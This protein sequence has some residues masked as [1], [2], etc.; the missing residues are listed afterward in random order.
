LWERHAGPIGLDSGALASKFRFTPGQIR[1]A[2][3][4]AVRQPAAEHAT[5]ADVYRAC[6]RRSVSKL[7]ALG[8]KATPVFQLCDIVLPPDALQQLREICWHA[9]HRE[10]VFGAW[11]FAGKM[12]LGRGLNALLIGAPGTGKTM[13]AEIIAAEIGLDLY[14]LDL[15][16][17]VSKYIGE[18]EK[19]LGQVFQEAARANAVLLF[20][21]AD[22]I[23]GKR[24]E[25]RDAHDRYANIEINYLLQKMEEFDGIVVLASNFHRNIDEAFRRRMRFVVEFPF[26]DEEARRRIWTKVFPQ[27]APLAAEV[28]FGFLAARFKMAGGNIRNVALAAAFLAAAH[29]TAIGMEE[30]V[31]AVRREFQKMGRV[32]VKSDFEQYV[33]LFEPEP[34]REEVTA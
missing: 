34:A 31:R 19:N 3:R 4:E 1:E 13:A 7:A 29:G 8:H 23:F 22:A 15:S 28:D 26:P 18:T 6:R 17:L 12:S 21:E 27:G 25:V 32:C 16:C 20:D 2:A 30:I 24:S 5:E 11:R 10:T 14:R 33:T 9:Q